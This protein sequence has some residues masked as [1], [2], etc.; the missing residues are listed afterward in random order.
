M[1]TKR[2]SGR[3]HI[4]YLLWLHQMRNKDTNTSLA[5]AYKSVSFKLHKNVPKALLELM[6]SEPAQDLRWGYQN[7]IKEC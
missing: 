3:N 7:K 5:Q 1:V 6:V 4:Y 2:A